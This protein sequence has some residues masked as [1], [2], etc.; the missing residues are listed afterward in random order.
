MLASL[1]TAVYALSISRAVSMLDFSSELG[2]CAERF[3]RGQIPCGTT[4]ASQITR[5]S[6]ASEG[7]LGRAQGWFLS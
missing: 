1:R 3:Q 6:A 4:P 2:P 5:L 7:R